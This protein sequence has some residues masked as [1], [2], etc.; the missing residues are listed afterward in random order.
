M[1]GA[2]NERLTGLKA[3]GAAHWTASSTSTARTSRTGTKACIVALANETR[4][5]VFSGDSKLRAI[6]AAP[7]GERRSLAEDF[8][9]FY[10][11]ELKDKELEFEGYLT[12]N[13]VQG[14][15]F[16]L[17]IASRKARSAAQPFFTYTMSEFSLKVFNDYAMV[18]AVW[19]EERLNVMNFERKSA[20]QMQVAINEAKDATNREWRD[21]PQS[22]IFPNTVIDTRT[23]LM[24]TWRIN[25]SACD[26]KWNDILAKET[27]LANLR[28]L[29]T[30]QADW[31]KP[32]LDGKDELRTLRGQFVQCLYDYGANAN[33]ATYDDRNGF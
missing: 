31:P 21:I 32:L 6:A 3:A 23:N 12:G 17:K 27:Q 20:E 29:R 22:R 19:L 10:K 30:K 24:W 18:Q 1:L 33:Q 9:D 14:V 2:V 8:V 5:A 25:P 26:P 15:D 28:A 16:N 13:G 4:G 11:R 7:V